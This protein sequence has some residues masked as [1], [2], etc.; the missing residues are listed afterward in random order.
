[1]P[2]GTPPTRCPF[3]CDGAFH[4]LSRRPKLH[5]CFLDLTSQGLCLKGTGA[6][7][8]RDGDPGLRS[9]L[10]QLLAFIIAQANGNAGAE[11]VSCGS[12]VQAAGVIGILA[13]KDRRLSSET[14]FRCSRESVSRSRGLFLL[15]RE[16]EPIGSLRQRPVCLLCRLVAGVVRFVTCMGAQC[17]FIA[18][19]SYIAGERVFSPTAA[20]L[21]SRRGERRQQRCKTGRIS[22]RCG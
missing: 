20:W 11:A 5:Q 12:C 15:R 22:G 7:I 6:E 21:F 9:A 13:L 17:V 4:R 1:M 19:G 16:R 2:P 18:Q 8:S 10:S 3:R 14:L